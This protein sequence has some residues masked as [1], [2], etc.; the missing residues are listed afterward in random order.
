MEIIFV[1]AVI[2]SADCCCKFWVCLQWKLL[3]RFANFHL[4]SVKLFTSVALNP[5]KHC[6]ASR[7]SQFKQKGFLSIEKATAAKTNRFCNPHLSPSIIN[8]ITTLQQ[9]LCRLTVL[10]LWP[11][12][13][14]QP[15]SMNACNSVNVKQG[16]RRTK[17]KVK[18][19][20]VW[21]RQSTSEIRFPKHCKCVSSWSTH[22]ESQM[23]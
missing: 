11:A 10:C 19:E 12:F 21:V 5:P 6:W 15:P 13:V 20:Y 17:K 22:N 3:L 23:H 7:Q 2:Y 8:I 4:M 18:N 1:D 9:L 16:R 14:R